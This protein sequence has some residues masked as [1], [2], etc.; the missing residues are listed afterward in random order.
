MVR[1]KV[2]D[3]GKP[4][5]AHLSSV[6]EA[7]HQERHQTRTETCHTE[8][9]LDEHDS[10]PHHQKSFLPSVSNSIKTKSSSLA[11]AAQKLPGRMQNFATA[12]PKRST[13]IV[14]GADDAS[15]SIDIPCDDWLV[16]TDHRESAR[17]HLFSSQSTSTAY[18]S[19]SDS[20][21]SWNSNIQDHQQSLHN[22]LAGHNS[23]SASLH[24]GHS[25]SASR[26]A[27]LPKM[28]RTHFEI[29]ADERHTE[30]ME[31]VEM[32]PEVNERPLVVVDGANVAY[33]Y[34][35]TMSQEEPNVQGLRAV[36][37]Y[38]AAAAGCVN[39]RI[40]L[41]ASW[42]RRKPRAGDANGTNAM[43]ETD[44]LAIL[45]EELKDLLI[46][47]PPTD[48]DDAYAIYTARRQQRH[49]VRNSL[50]SCPSYVLSNDLF[51]DAQERDVDIRDWLRH[52]LSE[53]TGPGRISY[54]FVDLGKRDSFG[55][56]ILDFLPNPRHPLIEW[57]E[58]QH[59]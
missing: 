35:Q 10:S 28:H 25:S 13:R 43:M 16:E 42:L 49:S 45:S 22:Q 20:R 55:D 6:N 15:R 24:F 3:E 23:T 11:Q 47:V 41:K 4:I 34:S 8:M 2:V 52:G 37:Q 58:K 17:D 36:A 48:D 44:Q 18:R 57:I 26:A 39:L 51:R 32:A 33:A 27:P 38:F 21:Y 53:E 54:T 7:A 50:A 40:V 9:I 5:A 12:N 1:P 30:R 29:G 14:I 46:I 59:A 31:G 56:P 19:P